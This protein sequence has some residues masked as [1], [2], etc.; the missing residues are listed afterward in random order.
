MKMH[1]KICKTGKNPSPKKKNYYS[2]NFY[3]TNFL[4]PHYEII[5]KGSIRKHHHTFAYALCF[6]IKMVCCIK[7]ILIWKCIQHKYVACVFTIKTQSVYA[8]DGVDCLIFTRLELNI[9]MYAYLYIGINI[10][11]M[12]YAIF[13]PSIRAMDLMWWITI[14]ILFVSYIKNYSSCWL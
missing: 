10:F 4:K 13:R 7:V 2:E 3:F 14:L 12:Q 11:P 8:V 6:V 9:C 5:Q 1:A